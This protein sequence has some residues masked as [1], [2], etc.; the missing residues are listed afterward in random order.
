[1]YSGSHF[2]ITTQDLSFDG[3]NASWLPLYNFNLCF[4]FI[5]LFMSRVK[6]LQ[7]SREIESVVKTIKLKD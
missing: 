7:P 4:I 5:F 6:M 1:M 2:L 3:E